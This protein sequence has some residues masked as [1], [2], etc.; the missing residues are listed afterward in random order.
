[1]WDNWNLGENIPYISNLVPG[2][3][4]TDALLPNAQEI[5]AGNRT[6]EEAGD[7]AAQVVEDWRAFNPDLLE[8]YQTWGEDLR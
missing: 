1:M 4:Y 8:N 5:I 2:Q 7:V 3:F 6:G